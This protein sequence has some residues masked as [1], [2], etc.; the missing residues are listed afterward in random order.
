MSDGS[1][2]GAS[3]RAGR[4][5]WLALAAALGFALDYARLARLAW[6]GR[7]DPILSEG[8]QLLSATFAH[9]FAVLAAVCALAALGAALRARWGV[10]LL[11]AGATAWWI[12]WGWGRL[13]G[14]AS[15]PSAL[16]VAATLAACVGAWGALARRVNLSKT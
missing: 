8:D 4:A 12:G 10:V 13:G 14:Y 3:R 15:A 5:A 1:L 6:D 9:V 7:D 2:F 16:A 11:A